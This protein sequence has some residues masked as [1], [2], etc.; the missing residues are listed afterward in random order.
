MLTKDATYI[1]E[2]KFKGSHGKKDAVILICFAL[3]PL[4]DV[5]RIA[6]SVCNFLL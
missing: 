3:F 5:R 4:N 2:V 1:E 6:T